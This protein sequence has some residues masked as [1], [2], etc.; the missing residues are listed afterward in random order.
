MRGGAVRRRCVGRPGAGLLRAERRAG[1]LLRDMAEHG[2]RDK[3]GGDTRPE[4]RALIQRPPVNRSRPMI[5][6]PPT[7][8]DLGISLNQSSQWQRAAAI[9]EP[10]FERPSLPARQH[11][12]AN[13]PA[14]QN[15][16]TYSY[17]DHDAQPKRHRAVLLQLAAQFA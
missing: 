7:L 3:G 16:R 1:E 10:T 8:T 4:S 11:R 15:E 6:L 2:E 5:D 9:P 17:Q 13:Q 14:A 12:Q